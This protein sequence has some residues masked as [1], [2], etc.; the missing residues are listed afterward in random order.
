MPHSALPRSQSEKTTNTVLGFIAI[1]F[2]VRFLD[3]FIIRS[4]EWFGEQVLTKVVG[5]ALVFAYLWFNHLPTRCIG[6]S[7]HRLMSGLWLG[8]I[9]MVTALLAGYIAEWLYLYFANQHPTFYLQAQGHRLTPEAATVGGF[10][11]AVLLLA[12]NVLNSLME[13]CFFRGFLMMHWLK[14]FSVRKAIVLQAIL[15]GLWHIFWSIRDYLAGA[16]DLPTFIGTTVV[17]CSIATLIGIAWGVLYWLTKNLWAVIIAH[18]LNNSVLNLLHLTTEQGAPNTI[19][20]R[21]TVTVLVFLAI[22][23]LLA[24]HQKAPSVTP[25]SR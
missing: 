25:S 17:Y 24:K 12:G 9:I 2:I 6:L 23:L 14:R 1:L 22:M 8:A 13:E 20:I 16:T 11:L 4:D 3:I 21:T 15:F 18:T 7:R 19:G 5:L 10:G